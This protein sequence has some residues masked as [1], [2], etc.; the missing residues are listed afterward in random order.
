MISQSR[1]GYFAVDFFCP[2]VEIEQNSKRIRR[3]LMGFLNITAKINQNE[4]YC[5]KMHRSKEIT[6]LST[7]I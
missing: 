1:L 2:N 4:A 7:A 6:K 3:V 5:I